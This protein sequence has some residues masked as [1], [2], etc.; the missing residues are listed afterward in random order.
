MSKV[1]IFDYDG[2]FYRSKEEIKI[3][4][5][6]IK[7]AKENGHIFV[8][9]TGRSYSSFMKEV[10]KFQIVYDYLILCSGG[11][12]LDRNHHIIHAF[13]MEH[14]RMDSLTLLMNNYQDLIIS[15][16]FISTFI[17]SK[18]YEPNLD[19][20]KVTYNFPKIDTVYQIKE[21]IQADFND[22]FKVYVI[23]T[24]TENLVEII[25]NKTDK[26]VAIQYL[27]NWINKK[28]D[29]IVAGDSENDLE[30][31]ET[32]NGYLMSNY[33]KNI[34]VNHTKIATSI[35]YILDLENII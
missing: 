27:L 33:D 1:L 29:I 32:F 30:M 15:N 21:S 24:H 18:T 19:I 8:V 25:S 16:M 31:I 4:I 35:Q 28:H 26:A 34:Q 11:L 14:E 20:L 10:E 6:L 12:I 5:E 22:A 2:T 13:N 17:N 23:P 7:K 3:N 9:A